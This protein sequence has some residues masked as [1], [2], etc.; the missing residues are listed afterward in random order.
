M[1]YNILVACDKAH[2]AGIILKGTISFFGLLGMIH[3]IIAKLEW[4]RSTQGDPAFYCVY[5]YTLTKLSAHRQKVM[6]LYRNYYN[7][8]TSLI[9]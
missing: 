6:S 1:C 4:L 5:M 8:T 2:K 7:I 9:P 3:Q